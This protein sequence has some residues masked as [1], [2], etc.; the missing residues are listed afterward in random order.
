MPTLCLAVVRRGLF[1]GGIEVGEQIT[2]RDDVDD[3]VLQNVA[4]PDAV[5]NMSSSAERVVQSVI[6]RTTA[7]WDKP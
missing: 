3:V 2:G 1:G 7:V 4:E 5:A 6:S